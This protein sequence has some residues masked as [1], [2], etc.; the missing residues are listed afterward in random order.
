MPT[1][2]RCRIFERWTKRPGAPVR[3]EGFG[4]A[5]F[6]CGA[7]IFMVRYRTEARQDPSQRAANSQKAKRETRL[8]RRKS[9]LLNLVSRPRSPPRD[10]ILWKAAININHQ[11][12]TGNWPAKD[13]VLLGPAMDSAAMR[14]R[15]LLN[16]HFGGRPAVFF[17]CPSCVGQL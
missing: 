9:L 3:P 10:E 2:S 16:L 13:D 14:A 11:L 17:Y 7:G 8:I 1:T 15:K 5:R 12:L 4:A 6:A